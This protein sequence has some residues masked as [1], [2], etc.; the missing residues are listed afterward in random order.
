MQTGGGGIAKGELPELE[1]KCLAKRN[2]SIE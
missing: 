1:H 2:N